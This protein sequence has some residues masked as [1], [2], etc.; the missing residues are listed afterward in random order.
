[1]VDRL[2]RELD[3]LKA[4]NEE[5]R[6]SARARAPEEDQ[7]AAIR[8]SIA[9]LN[10][11]MPMLATQAAQAAVAAHAAASKKLESPA[12][13]NAMV[14]LVTEAAQGVG[15]WSD[16]GVAVK[17]PAIQDEIARRIM[18]QPQVLGNA[19]AQGKF[20]DADRRISREL[21]FAHVVEVI[22]PSFEKSSSKSLKT[23]A[24]TARNA[25][26][27]SASRRVSVV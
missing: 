26:Q 3:E 1:M 25:I 17:R 19:E 22:C 9:E 11:K 12:L 7:L 13:S 24:E 14:Q 4:Q 8:Q 20:R 10:Q 2:K 23:I 6:A 21:V 15:M 27:V 18:D 5:L 16:V